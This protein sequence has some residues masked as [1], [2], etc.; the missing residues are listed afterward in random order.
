MFAIGSVLTFSWPDEML[1]EAVVI[2][3]SIPK[4]DFRKRI[5]NSILLF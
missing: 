1:Q 3:D 2:I 5:H 4:D